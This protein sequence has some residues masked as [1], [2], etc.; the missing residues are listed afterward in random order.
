MRCTRRPGGGRG[1]RRRRTERPKRGAILFRGHYTN[2]FGD[3]I[4][5]SSPPPGSAIDTKPQPTTSTILPDACATRPSIISCAVI[6]RKRGADPHRQRAVADLG[7]DACQILRIDPH[8]DQARLGPRSSARVA[9][10]CETAEIRIPPARSRQLWIVASTIARELKRNSR[11]RVGSKPAYADQHSEYSG[12]NA[13][14]SAG[15]FVRQQARVPK[16]SA[17]SAESSS[18]LPQR[19]HRSFD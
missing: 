1:R 3:T 2:N 15:H 17:L 12:D 11:I 14:I 10:G 18:P 19:S 8:E 13:F 9:S 6:A 4:V 7:R 5:N 16:I